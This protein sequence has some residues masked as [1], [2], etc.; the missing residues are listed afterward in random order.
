MPGH[1]QVVS[2]FNA[3]HARS[4]PVAYKGVKVGWPVRFV[5]PVIVLSMLSRVMGHVKVSN[6]RQF[7]KLLKVESGY[8]TSGQANMRPPIR[9]AGCCKKRVRGDHTRRFRLGRKHLGAIIYIKNSG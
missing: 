6:T 9:E 4:Y 1:N 5:M 2:T 3:E 7:Q 8:M